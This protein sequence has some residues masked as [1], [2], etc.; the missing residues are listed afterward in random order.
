V[1]TYGRKPRIATKPRPTLQNKLR[2]LPA[3]ANLRAALLVIF[4]SCQSPSAPLIAETDGSYVRIPDSSTKVIVWGDNSEAIKTLKSWLLKRR[5]ALIDE[6]RIRQI[7]TEM[8]LH[9]APQT[10]MSSR[11]QNGW[12]Q[13]SH[14]RR[15]RRLHSSEWYRHIWTASSQ[16]LHLRSGIN[17][18]QL[19]LIGME[20]HGGLNRSPCIDRGL[21]TR[22]HL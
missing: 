8:G 20:R 11:R 4:T 18:T 22:E 17:W 2:L 12:S 19:K 10:P 7:A 6:A 3:R 16:R 9:N 14:F 5:I 21:L 13:A 1:T 15:C